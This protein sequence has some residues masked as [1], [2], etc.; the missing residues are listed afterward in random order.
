VSSAL[1]FPPGLT[2]CTLFSSFL[3]RDVLYVPPSTALPLLVV[4]GVSFCRVVPSL[5]SCFSLPPIGSMPVPG[6]FFPSLFFFI[7]L[8]Q[9]VR[10]RCGVQ[11]FFLLSRDRTFRSP[12]TFHPHP[13]CEIRRTTPCLGRNPFFPACVCFT[14]TFFPQERCPDVFFLYSCQTSVEC[15]VPDQQV[16]FPL[17]EK[18][19]VE[20]FR[21]VDL[22]K[23]L[24]FCRQMASISPSSGTFFPA[25]S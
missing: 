10:E 16:L 19:A 2:F 22:G 8:A 12:P 20:F 6:A 15:F 25:F 3:P 18:Q 23:P 4:E 13:S 11:S 24:P 5:R 9:N 1:I 14:P 17:P 21:G 7:R